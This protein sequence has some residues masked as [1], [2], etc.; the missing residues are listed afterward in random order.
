MGILFGAPKASRERHMEKDKNIE[1]FI[2]KSNNQ[3]TVHEIV[4]KICDLWS[5]L[6]TNTTF[7][8][9]RRVICLDVALPHS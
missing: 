5:F 7:S 2:K 4:K 3:Q 8:V 1:E 6:V 9:V